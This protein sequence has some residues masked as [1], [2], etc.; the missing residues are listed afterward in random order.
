M[1]FAIVSTPIQLRVVDTPLKIA[2]SNAVVKAAAKIEVPVSLERLYGFADAVE[3]TVEFPKGVT[4]LA[5]EKLSIAKDQ[6]E[7][8][9][10]VAATDKAPVGD[11]SITIRAKAK[12]NNIDVQASQQIVLKIEAA[13]E[14]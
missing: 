13:A 12:F 2:A 14:K 8:K 3:I 1:N 10:Q 5:V 4:G 11:H 9:L 7:A 6:K